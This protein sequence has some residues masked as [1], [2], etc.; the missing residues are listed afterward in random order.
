MLHITES[1]AAQIKKLSKGKALRLRVLGGGCA[2]F[3]YTFELDEKRDEDI[4]YIKNDAS[5][6]TDQAS[7]DL[8]N[9]STIDFIQDLMGERFV[10]KNPNATVSCGCGNSFS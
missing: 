5:V 6:I 3:Q 8:I 10:I 7:L 2:G 9:G 4:I 1:A